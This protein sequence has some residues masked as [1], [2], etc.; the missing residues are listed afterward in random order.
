MGTAKSRKKE[1][2][3]I[4]TLVRKKVPDRAEQTMEILF[5]W[6]LL[7]FLELLGDIMRSKT[8]L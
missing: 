5:L 8:S 3:V 4:E 1:Q 6:I 2:V 7:S